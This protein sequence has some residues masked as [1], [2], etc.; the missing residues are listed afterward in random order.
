MKTPRPMSAALAGLIM[1]GLTATAGARSPKMKMTTP[2]PSE[3]TTPDTVETRLGALKF[4]HGMPDQATI[5]KLYDNLDFARGVEVYLNALPG[6]SLYANRKGM[7]DAG[8]PDNTL[9]T[10]EQMCDSTGMFLTPNT[11]TPQTWPFLNLKNGP[12]VV[13]LPPN[14][15]GLADDMWFRYIT[16]L[17]FLGPDK[18]KGGKYLFLP[19]GFKGDVPEGYFVVR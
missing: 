16:D 9:V 1:A 5:Q 19:P 18:G 4:T 13:V 2:I 3:I 15:L 12:L 8:F 6:V 11:V 14:V 10:M 17:G 7:R